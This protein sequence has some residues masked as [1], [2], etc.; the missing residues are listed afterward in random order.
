M[1]TWPLKYA[2]LHTGKRLFDK[3]EIFSSILF[4][5]KF[6]LNHNPISFLQILS[7]ESFSDTL[8]L[9]LFDHSLLLRRQHLYLSDATKMFTKGCL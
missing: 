4:F 8:K 3:V 1:K 9:N 5:F 2:L 6:S 7:F